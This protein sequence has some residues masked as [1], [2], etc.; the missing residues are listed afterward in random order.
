VRF[1]SLVKAGAPGPGPDSLQGEFSHT[2]PATAPAAAP[3]FAPPAQVPV[4]PAAAPGAPLLN[5]DGVPI[6]N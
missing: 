5:G 4:D 3:A 1:V 6:D 2:A